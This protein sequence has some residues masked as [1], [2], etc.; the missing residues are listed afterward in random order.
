[1][2]AR[3]YQW[4]PWHNNGHYESW[5]VARA[6]GDLAA[7][8]R[9]TAHYRRGLTAVVGRADNGFRIGVP[10]IWCSNNL[11]TSFATQAYLYRRMTGDQ[12]FRGYEQAAVDWLL[13]ANP[14]GVS[15]VIGYPHDGVTARDPHSAVSARLGV[16][17]LLGGLL[18]GPVYRSIYGSLKG[19]ALHEPDEY[20]RFNGGRMV[21]HDDLGDYSTNEPIMDGTAS[22]A[23]LLAAMADRP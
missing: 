7:R 8:R 6:R 9:M 12:R 10:F 14:W 19:I 17:K 13:G 22:L 15:M 5:R 16:D 23:Y 11:M 20:A 1:D 3:H 21:Y 4:F 2:T 18:D